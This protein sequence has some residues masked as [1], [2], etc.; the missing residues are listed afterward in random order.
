MNKKEVTFNGT[1][2]PV[3]FNMQALL[4]YEDI[5][6]QSFFGEDF[7]LLKNRMALIMAAA[8]AADKDTKLDIDI[9]KGTE[10]IEAVHQIAEAFKVVMT[11][12]GQ[13]MHIPDVVAEAEQAEQPEE[14]ESDQKETDGN[15]KNA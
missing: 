15:G 11:M 8:L 2:Y 5:T 9:I 13:F 4:N 14:D 6:K 12:V 1:Q 10:D 3:V 7:N